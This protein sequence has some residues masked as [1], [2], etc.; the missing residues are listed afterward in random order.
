MCLGDSSHTDEQPDGEPEPKSLPEQYAQ[1][2]FT[3]VPQRRSAAI[4][5]GCT[6][7]GIR[8]AQDA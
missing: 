5:R 6:G 8:H 1:Q 4:D 2:S 3:H 7:A